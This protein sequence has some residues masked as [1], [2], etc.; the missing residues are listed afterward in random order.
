MS[1]LSPVT[2]SR[3]R[4]DVLDEQFVVHDDVWAAAVTAGDRLLAT[5]LLRP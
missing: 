3:C 4:A 5:P 1:A 2:C